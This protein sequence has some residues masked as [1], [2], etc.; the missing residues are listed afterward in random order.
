MVEYP[1]LFQFME[2]KQLAFL[3]QVRLLAVST[4]VPFPASN[5]TGVAAW[6]GENDVCRMARVN[7]REIRR[8]IE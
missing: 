7:S 5:K 8:F 6:E 1:V 2:P 4:M 3:S